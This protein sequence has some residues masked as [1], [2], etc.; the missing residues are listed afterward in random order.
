MATAI[1]KALS[2]DGTHAVGAINSI[3]VQTLANGARITVAAV[4]NWNLV[5]LAGFNEDGERLCKALSDQAKP[6]YLVA[7][8]EQRFLGE[9]I[10]H[11]YNDVDEFARLVL[12][13]SHYTRFEASNYSLNSGVTEIEVGQVAHFDTA[14]KKFI[15]SKASDAHDDFA[16]AAFQFEVVADLDDTAGNFLVPT[17]RLMSIKTGY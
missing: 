11:F 5:E 8:P 6:A 15:I 17:V 12:L 7:T 9:D 10:A 14:T 4:D 1:L 2:N 3:Q 13:V 16:T